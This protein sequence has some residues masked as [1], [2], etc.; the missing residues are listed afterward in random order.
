MTQGFKNANDGL[1]DIY[2]IVVGKNGAEYISQLSKNNLDL[3]EQT[4]VV[5]TLGMRSDPR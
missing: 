4:I 2:S 3:T 5:S 1:Q